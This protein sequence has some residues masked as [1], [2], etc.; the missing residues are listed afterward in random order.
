MKD[1]RTYFFCLQIE[2]KWLY[3]ASVI[4]ILSSKKLEN[5]GITLAQ[6]HLPFPYA[7]SKP[8]FLKIRRSVLITRVYIMQNLLQIVC[9]GRVH[10]LNMFAQ[11]LA[12]DVVWF[13]NPFF[14]QLI[15]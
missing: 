15:Q 4:V 8:R 12:G 7:Y 6:Y 1:L 5:K 9:F 2:G 10:Y 3:F 14:M 11:E 13:S